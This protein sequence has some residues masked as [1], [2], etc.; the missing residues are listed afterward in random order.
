MGKPYWGC[1]QI[2][3][4]FQTDKP[5]SENAVIHLFSQ[6]QVSDEAEVYFVGCAIIRV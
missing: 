4:S 3:N 1:S 5:Y 6:E 2:Y